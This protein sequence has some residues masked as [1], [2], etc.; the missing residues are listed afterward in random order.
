M[1]GLETQGS[2][3]GD[4]R[5]IS[6][7]VVHA[8]RGDFC[9]ETVVIAPPRADEILVRIVA[10][11]VCHTDI[12]VRDG[13]VPFPLP[14]VLG[15]EGAGIVETVGSQ[16]E[17]LLPGDHVILTFLS[18][19]ECRQCLVGRTSNCENAGTLCFSG[20]RPDGSHAL[21]AEEGAELHDRFMGQSS[22][23]QFAIAHHRSVVKVLTDVP[24][25][26][27]G[28]LGC[29][30]ITGAGSVWN[31]LAAD[32]TTSLAVFG[33]GAVGLSAIMAANV[34]GARPIIAIDRVAS[35][36]ELA[37]ELGATHVIDTSREDLGEALKAIL[38]LGVD[39][40]FDTTGKL[41]VIETAFGLLR[42]SGKLATVAVSEMGKLQLDL[43][44]MIA[45][46]KT[47]CGV[48][49]GGGAA[50]EIIA[51]VLDLHVAGDFPF[52]RMIEFYPFSDIN[53]AVADA[54][55]GGVIK[56]V[57]LF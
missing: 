50:S 16:V 31:A 55:S 3:L 39:R 40:A 46:G 17:N 28:P 5:Q 11:G 25:N 13:V 9:C 7:A 29:G 15:H 26:L 37:L 41:A 2:E 38:P 8:T 21:A 45:M 52:D 24:L 14:M 35:R 32:A 53:R 1:D 44:D 18:C 22:F 23:A 33:A 34:S 36:L 49:G 56:P 48:T 51:R 47:I 4:S 43:V 30:V 54:N 20:A 57:L 19:G 12:H 6:A 10:T 27:L 42:H